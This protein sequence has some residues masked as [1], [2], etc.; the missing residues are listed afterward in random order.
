MKTPG[1]IL[2][3]ILLLFLLFLF[4][5]TF[6]NAQTPAEM[7]K[8][9]IGLRFNGINNFGVIYKYHLKDNKYRRWRL[10]SGGITVQN[11]NFTS[12][13]IGF[14][15]AFGSEKRLPIAEKASFLHGP[16][17][18]GSLSFA[19][20]NTTNT[21]ILSPGAGYVLGFLYQPNEMFSISLEGA[22][23]L[24]TNYHFVSGNRDWVDSASI[25]LQFNSN[26]VALNLIYCFESKRKTKK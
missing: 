23:F 8:R 14:G 18:S 1:A 19:S 24:Y 22:I 5:S 17:F 15:A 13:N 25:S 2:K 9:E 4:S 7:R 10:A 21:F 12:L 6:L 20:N 3:P 11:T 16:E 26:N